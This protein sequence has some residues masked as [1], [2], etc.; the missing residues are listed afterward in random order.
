MVNNGQNGEL[1]SLQ[2]IDNKTLQWTYQH[3]HQS[4]IISTVTIVNE[5]N[6]NKYDFKGILE[7]ILFQ[8]MSEDEHRIQLF[9]NVTYYL[10]N[11]K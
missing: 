10:F 4:K 9:L 7:G 3:L 6:S 2:L 8:T 5:N 1:F 11:L